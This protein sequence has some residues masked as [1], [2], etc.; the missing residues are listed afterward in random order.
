MA[1]RDQ[2]QHAD[3]VI[4]HLNIVIP[5]IENPLLT[6]KYC[7]FVAVVAVTVYELAI[8]EIFCDFARRKLK[9]LGA[10]AES[11]FRRINGRVTLSD[12]REEYCARYGKNYAD[13]FK[14]NLDALTAT[15]LA[16]HRRDIKS[17]YSNLV[18]WRHAFAHEGKVPATVTYA[19]VV[20]AYQDGKEVIHSLAASIVR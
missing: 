5:A 15:F 2:F 17:A 4:A 20:V 19:E 18:L 16:T 14:K 3:E 12:I 10:F 1:Y 11:Y 8:K 7:G 13:K 6:T 9:V